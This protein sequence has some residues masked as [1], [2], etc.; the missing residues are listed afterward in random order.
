MSR[1]RK[2]RF[3]KFFSCNPDQSTLFAVNADIDLNDA[4]EQ[5]STFLSAAE[6]VVRD[7]AMKNGG[8]ENA[9]AALYLVQISRVLV[10]A[11]ISAEAEEGGR[12]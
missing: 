10:N 6:N 2:T 4:L 7:L 11:S 3:T 5:A 8:N 1:Q 9:F 12:Q